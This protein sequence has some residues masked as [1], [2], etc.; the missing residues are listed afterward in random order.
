MLFDAS[1]EK[2]M[3]L[4]MKTRSGESLRRLQE[5]HGHAEKLFLEQVWW[6]AVGR[7]DFLHAE[8]QVSDFKD[9]DRY[10]DFAFIFAGLIWSVSRLMATRRIIKK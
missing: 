9:G 3:H 4:Q 8:Y 6:P 5:G 7:F 1:Y 10:L 2:F